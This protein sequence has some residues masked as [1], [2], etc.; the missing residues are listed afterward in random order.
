MTYKIVFFDIDG[1]LVKRDGTIDDSTKQAIS[2]LQEKGIEVVLATGRNYKKTIEVAA[3]LAID[4]YI[5]YNGSYVVHKGKVLHKHTIPHERV[6][7][8]LNDVSQNNGAAACFGLDKD[9]YTDIHHPIVQLAN[10]VHVS[11]EPLQSIERN[12]IKDVIGM[13][14]YAH[15]SEEV[16]RYKERFLDLS[17][18]QWNTLQ[19]CCDI[20]LLNISKATG[21]QHILKHL[22]IPKEKAIAFGDGDNDKE[23]L[24]YVGL[25]VAMGNAA[26]SLLTYSDRQTSHVEESGVYHGLK[27]I[28]LLD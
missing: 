25:G 27:Q 10:D 7:E 8:F 23:M 18:V 11:N 9:Y 13:V 12:E 19:H 14:L 24:S 28:G 5:S 15:S 22:S 26:P 21:V 20:S 3:Q 1:T 2:F 4:S 6:D 16:T 17:F